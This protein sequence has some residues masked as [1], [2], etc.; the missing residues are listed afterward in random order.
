MDGYVTIALREVR[1][2]KESTI[3][4]KSSHVEWLKELFL[5]SGVPGGYHTSRVYRHDCGRRVES[6]QKNVERTC[7]QFGFVNVRL[8]PRSKLP[9]WTIEQGRRCVKCALP[10]FPRSAL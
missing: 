5:D 8:S 10:V 9:W 4:K 2:P 6:T 1:V 3:I 7:S